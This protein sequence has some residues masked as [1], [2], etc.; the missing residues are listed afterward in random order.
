M[1][2]TNK[3]LKKYNDYL[4][5]NVFGLQFNHLL[6]NYPSDKI[7]CIDMVQQASGNNLYDLLTKLKMVEFNLID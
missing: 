2:C 3:K 4:L 5:M 7:F 6:T 1:N